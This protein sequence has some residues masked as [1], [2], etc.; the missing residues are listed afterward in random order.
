ME[1]VFRIE[2]RRQ[3]KSLPIEIQYDKIIWSGQSWAAGEVRS[4]EIAG[5][6]PLVITCSS[7][8]KDEVRLEVKLYAVKYR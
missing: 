2:V 7:G 4:A 6:E 5:N 1:K 8:E 3:A